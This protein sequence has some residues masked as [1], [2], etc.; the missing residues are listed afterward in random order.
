MPVTPLVVTT[1]NLMRRR[2]PSGESRD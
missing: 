2:S 1:S